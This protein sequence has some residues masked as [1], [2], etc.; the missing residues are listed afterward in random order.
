MEVVPPALS[1]TPT[2]KHVFDS[3]MD[4]LTANEEE[5]NSS[6]RAKD[7]K[8]KR[9]RDRSMETQT[10]D[11]SEENHLR[12]PKLVRPLIITPRKHKS[13][14]AAGKVCTLLEFIS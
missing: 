11:Q 12:A 3:R 2:E 5:E 13:E 8:K 14:N 6:A 1:S 9:S 4:K 7:H 10:V